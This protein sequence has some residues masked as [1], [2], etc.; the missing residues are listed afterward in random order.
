[1]K[2]ELYRVVKFLRSA[3]PCT[4]LAKETH[5]PLSVF[6]DAALEGN[7]SIATIGDVKFDGASCEFFPAQLSIVQ[8]ASLQ[9]DSRHVIAV[10]EVLPV[11]CAMQIWSE[12]HSIE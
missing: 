6:T 8:L 9:T 12:G 11:V 5:R 2:A 10:F 4:L 3:A 7:E 1:M